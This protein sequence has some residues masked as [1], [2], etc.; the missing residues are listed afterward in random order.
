V[1]NLRAD[2][3]ASSMLNLF[4]TDQVPLLWFQVGDTLGNLYIF[5][6]PD[7][8]LISTVNVFPYGFDEIDC[9]PQKKWVL[10]SKNYPHILPKV[11]LF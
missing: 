9:S 10:L 1:V 5:R 2:H 3:T 6:I 7:L 11:G 8:H 4:P